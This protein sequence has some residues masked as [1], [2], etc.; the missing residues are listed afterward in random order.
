MNLLRN[1]FRFPD[2]SLNNLKALVIPVKAPAY[3]K[4]YRQLGQFCYKWGKRVVET[5]TK[6][7]N[8]TLTEH[9]ISLIEDYLK[10]VPM[11]NNEQEFRTNVEQV[12]E[13]IGRT[14]LIEYSEDLADTV[15][16]VPIMQQ[17]EQVTVKLYK[18]F[19]WLYQYGHVT[20]GLLQ[21]WRMVSNRL[22]ELYS[23]AAKAYFESL[24]IV[25]GDVNASL[26]LLR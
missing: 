13:L 9:E 7:G 14:Q 20:A 12:K 2:N 21:I 19:P 15:D 6:T 8:V 11:W 26:R 22:F 4:A 24:R 18:T 25:G 3:P 17:E 23:N 16:H 1:V 5:A 10:Q